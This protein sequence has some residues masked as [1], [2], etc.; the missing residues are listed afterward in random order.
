MPQHPKP[1]RP[2]LQT[3]ST[4]PGAHRPHLHPPQLASA[5]PLSQPHHQHTSQR[6]HASDPHPLPSSPALTC[7]HPPPPSPGPTSPA[8]NPPLPILELATIHLGYS[9]VKKKKVG[10]W[11][12]WQRFASYDEEIH[13]DEDWLRRRQLRRCELD[14]MKTAAAMAGRDEDSGGEGWM[15]RRRLRWRA[16]G[17]CEEVGIGLSPLIQLLADLLRSKRERGVCPLREKLNFNRI[18]G[19]IKKSHIFVL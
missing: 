10:I 8:P 18:F 15:G 4:S 9:K 16:C 13:G 3:H 11:R 19:N 14:A 7:P 1:N 2:L 6:P 17:G 12:R 5:P